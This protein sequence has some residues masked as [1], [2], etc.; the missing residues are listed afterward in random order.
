[1]LHNDL[2]D[3]SLWGGGGGDF[4]FPFP[5]LKVE[6]QPVCRF[7]YSPADCTTSFVDMSFLGGIC[8]TFHFPVLR[9]EQ[10]PAWI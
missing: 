8:S 2:L 1:M 6:Q 3:V 5:V 7:L 4:D 10:R 9:V